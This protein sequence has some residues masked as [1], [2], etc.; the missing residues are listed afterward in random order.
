MIVVQRGSEAMPARVDSAGFRFTSPKA[1]EPAAALV[2]VALAAYVLL[3][4]PLARA[5]GFFERRLVERFSGAR[6]ASARSRRR[7]IVLRGIARELPAS[8]S[9]SLVVLAATA[10]LVLLSLGKSLLAP[11]VD[12]VALPLSTLAA[13]GTTT[14]AVGGGGARW[15]LRHG[16]ER[17]AALLL[18]QV[19]FG[20]VLVL[21][22]MTTGSLSARTL[23][24]AQ[25]PWPWQWNLTATPAL[26]IAGIAALCALVPRARSAGALATGRL[27]TRREQALEL[28]AFTHQMVVVSVLVVILFGGW[29]VPPRAGLALQ[30]LGAAS[31]VA[32]VWGILVAV[33]TARWVMGPLDV[34]GV[35]RA[36]VLWLCLPSLIAAVLSLTLGGTELG[37]ICLG[38]AEGFGPALVLGTALGAVLVTRRAIAALGSR[39]AEIGVHAWL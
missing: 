36:T 30:L 26:A 4:T 33:A 18:Q 14:L 19:P 15:S 27:G 12:L 34:L 21:A 17:L 25:G 29:G 5:F 7:E 20:I 2:G 13:L 16:L 11:E 6:R 23:V 24:S 38:I 10:A 35:R 28:S 39:P 37:A 32:K 22:A 1:L 31:A 3:C 9:R 8:F